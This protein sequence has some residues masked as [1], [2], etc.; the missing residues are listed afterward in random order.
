MTDTLTPA[1]R[2]ARVT[3]GVVESLL[4]QG[5][6]AEVSTDG[7]VITVGLPDPRET[8]QHGNRIAREGCTRCPC[9]AKYWEADRCVSCGGSVDQ[10]PAAD[11]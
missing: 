1:E 8:D 5:Y 11:R 3:A 10:V 2:L 4:A 6:P 7:T 9:G